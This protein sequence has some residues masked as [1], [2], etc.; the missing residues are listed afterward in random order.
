MITTVCNNVDQLAKQDTNN[1][2]NEGKSLAFDLKPKLEPIASCENIRELI[3]SSES[4]T[5]T[6]P[7]TDSESKKRTSEVRDSIDESMNQ[8]KD[9]KNFSFLKHSPIKVLKVFG[10]STSKYSVINFE[11]LKRQ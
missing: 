2:A 1:S 9:R 11:I 7:T 4:F 8:T 6:Q 5:E 3:S 10:L